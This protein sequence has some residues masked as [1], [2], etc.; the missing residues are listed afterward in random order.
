[1][2]LDDEKDSFREKESSWEKKPHHPRIV[3][4]P[5]DILVRTSDVHRLSD[6][7]MWQV[8]FLSLPHPSLPSNPRPFPFIPSTAYSFLLIR[9]VDVKRDAITFRQGALAAVRVAGDGAG[10]VGLA[11]GGSNAPV[12]GLSVRLASRHGDDGTAIWR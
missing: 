7:L 9:W 8:R 10:V 3:A 6:F 5:L 12:E 4:P 11:E 1:M 2:P